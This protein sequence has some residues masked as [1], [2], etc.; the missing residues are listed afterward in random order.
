MCRPVVNGVN[1]AGLCARS[2]VCQLHARS[3]GLGCL[4]KFHDDEAKLSV[5]AAL[6]ERARDCNC[7]FFPIPL[8][9]SPANNKCVY[10]R[11]RSGH[12]S[13]CAAV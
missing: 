11:P 9:I 8:E 2:P 13:E 12:V 7:L 5:S 4:A 1:V 6:N 10:V 3:R